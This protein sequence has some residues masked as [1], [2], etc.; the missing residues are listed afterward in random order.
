VRPDG[1]DPPTAHPATRL[2]SSVNAADLAEGRP[3]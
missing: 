2:I 1:R 3:P